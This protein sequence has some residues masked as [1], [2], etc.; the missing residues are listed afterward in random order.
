MAPRKDRKPWD[1]AVCMMVAMMFISS[2]LSGVLT[3][4]GSV[5]SAGHT[6]DLDQAIADVEATTDKAL[7]ARSTFGDIDVQYYE[8]VIDGFE[9]MNDSILVQTDNDTGELIKYEKQWRSINETI[10]PDSTSGFEPEKPYVWTEKVVFLAKADGGWFYSFDVDQDFPLAC[11]E[12]RYK[13]GTTLLH[14]FDGDVI[15]SGVP[16]PS[17]KGFSMNGYCNSR[18]PDHWRKLSEN[19]DKWFSKWLDE[20]ARVSLPTP[21]QVSSY[22]KDDHVSCFYESAHGNYEYFQCGERSTYEVADAIEDMKGRPPMKFAF[23]GSCGGMDSTGPGSFSYAFRKGKIENTTTVGYYQVTGEGWRYTLPWQDLMFQKM[24]GNYTVKKAFNRAC[25][26]YPV[27]AKQVK[28]RGDPNLKIT[29]DIDY[30]YY[31]EKPEAPTGPTRVNR[32]ETYTYRAATT[33]PEGEHLYYQWD[34]NDGTISDWMGPYESGETVS[35]EHNF[36]WSGVIPPEDR[37]NV[38]VRAK[39][40]RG[41]ITEWSDPLSVAEPYARASPVR[42]WITEWF[43]HLFGSTI[44]PGISKTG[45]FIQ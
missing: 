26:R 6:S 19:A 16:A 30:N 21:E 8:H 22:I 2:G 4:G 10:I 15:G 24:D 7:T 20:S 1:M 44:F 14:D 29:D 31:P 33:E 18:D 38:Q 13:D 41:A 25:A 32:L 36:D 11:R 28:F 39:D 35:A 3:D 12:V 17:E 5:F 23:L 40:E 27:I 34:W 43:T 37:Y 45:C 9:V 42:D